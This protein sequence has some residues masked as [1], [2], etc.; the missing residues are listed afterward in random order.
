MRYFADFLTLGNL[1]SGCLSLGFL[2]RQNVGASAM[3]ILVAVL[4][5]GMDGYVAR[6]FG[7]AGEF[8]KNLDSFA[9]MVSFGVAPACLVYLFLLDANHVAFLDRNMV[10]I[11]MI[12]PVGYAVCA[13]LRLSRYNV[14]VASEAAVSFLGLPTTISGAAIASV[15]LLHVHRTLEPRP[16]LFVVSLAVLSLLMISRIRY[17]NMRGIRKLFVARKLLIGFCWCVLVS[18]TAWM[19]KEGGVAG[20]FLTGMFLVYIVFFP[21]L[22]KNFV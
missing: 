16:L 13:A 2:L 19:G 4:L 15:V 14:N 6:K 17:P 8:G 3:L 9:D 7:T 5:D 1:I 18:L 20:L 21:L 22:K 12:V 10:I 11:G